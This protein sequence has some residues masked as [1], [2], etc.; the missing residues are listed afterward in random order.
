MLKHDPDTP[1]SRLRFEDDVPDA[2]VGTSGQNVQKKKSK[3][4][5]NAVLPTD[6]VLEAALLG[7][8]APDTQHGRISLFIESLKK[9]AQN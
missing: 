9:C 2:P 4:F 3:Y 6:P 5:R 8:T 7:L 1:K